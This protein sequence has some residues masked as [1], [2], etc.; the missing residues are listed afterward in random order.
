[1]AQDV[2]AGLAQRQLDVEGAVV[3]DPHLG[4]RSPHD[5]TGHRDG[6]LVARQVQ[7]E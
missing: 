6:L 7:A 5:V 1:V 3:L 4:E 2:G